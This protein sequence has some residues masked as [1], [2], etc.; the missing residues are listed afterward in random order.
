M[1]KL[2]KVRKPRDP[3]FEVLR[4]RKGGPMTSYERKQTRREKRYID[5]ELSALQT[6]GKKNYDET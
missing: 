1:S 6:N 2:Q 5:D 3:N 4:T